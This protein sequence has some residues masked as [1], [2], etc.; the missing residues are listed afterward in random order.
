MYNG[1]NKVIKHK[2][3]L[4][5]LAKELGNLSKACQIMGTSRDTFYR[6]KAAV[7][8]RGLEAL[9]EKDRKKPNIKNRVEKHIEQA[10]VEYAIKFPAHGQ[11]RATNCVKKGPLSLQV[12]SVAYGSDTI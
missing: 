9:L 11:Q 2:I 6:Y 5:S 10:V 12:E 8:E 7:E 1:N 4:L 3:G